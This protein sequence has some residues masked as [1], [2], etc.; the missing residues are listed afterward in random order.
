[1]HRSRRKVAGHCVTLPCKLKSTLEHRSFKGSQISDKSLLS[2]GATAQQAMEGSAQQPTPL[3]PGQTNTQYAS[4]LPAHSDVQQHRS[5]LQ[6]VGDLAVK[7]GYS[8]TAGF[9]AG[10]GGDHAGFRASR[11]TTPDVTD[12]SSRL[13]SK[14]QEGTAHL[15]GTTDGMKGSWLTQLIGKTTHKAKQKCEQ[16]PVGYIIPICSCSSCLCA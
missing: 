3:A 5:P 10:Q 15:S 12:T 6:S 14:D 2:R 1:M 4:N 16:L 11:P 8:D 13:A 7:P 9:D